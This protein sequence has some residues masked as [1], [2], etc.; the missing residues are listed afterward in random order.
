MHFNSIIIFL[1]KFF[2]NFLIA[3]QGKEKNFTAG[4]INKAIFMLSIPMIL[5]M[6]MESLF[7]VVDV[8]FVS[9]VS[10]NAVAT[11][12]LTESVIMLIYA[13][14]IGLSM[15]TTAMVA[16]RVGEKNV[17]AASDAAFHAVFLASAIAIFFG[18]LGAFLAEDILRL[19][20]GSEELI[21]EGSGYTKILLGGN[22]TIMLLF[23]ING[24]YRGAGDASLAMRSLWLAN[25]L[26][27][28][29]DPIFIFGLGPIPA[30]GVE[31]AAI[32]TTIGRGAGVLYQLYSLLGKKSIIDLTGINYVIK[33]SLLKN[34]FNIS[35]GG[36]GQFL[37]GTASWIFLV[38]IIAVFGNEALA[39]YTISFRIIM[40]TILPS[41]GLANA[42]ATL[43][44]QN[45]GA[46][47]AA[48]AES[49]VWKCAFYNM[50]F[51]ALLSVVLIYWAEDFV[52]IFS[53]IPEV[54]RYGKASLTYICIGYVFFAYGMVINQAFNGAGDTRT[55]TV[56][57]FFCY[58]LLQLPMAYLLAVMLDMG[59]D[60]VFIT[61]A[62]SV[63]LLA[64]ISIFIFK[65][66][67]WKEVA[68]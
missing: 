52:K 22:I 21:K 65:K 37:I 28:V 12:G 1:T 4:S 30:F 58:W 63:S 55:P 43:V 68:I 67:R 36:M 5:E 61:I 13:I 47:Q 23:L 44:G 27:L 32:A 25:G 38:R 60:G 41:W 51:L 34:I 62:F 42:A 48:R 56:I 6:I 24:V 15:A 20:G 40:F 31:G 29:L 3:V 54:V 39:G 33:P 46:K 59:P 26:N 16:R 45:L 8:F 35:L 10:V 11:V 53:S 57:N 66:G 64:V 50:I 17:K 14:A 9:K 7:A 49:S 2:K 18:G 19:M